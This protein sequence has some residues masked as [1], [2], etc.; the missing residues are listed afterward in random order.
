VN[1]MTMD[2]GRFAETKQMGD[3][4]IAAAQAAI[5][6]LRQLG[7]HA[8]L[9]ITPMLGVNDVAGET[10]TLAD[11]TA[12]TA[13]ARQNKDVALLA[14]WSIGRDNGSCS[15]QVSPLCSGVE[16]TEWQFARIFAAF[17]E[18]RPRK[19]IVFEGK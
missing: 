9:G 10:F 11:A 15:A 14:Y 16:Q 18:Q 4:A 17:V 8:R 2:Y 3:N 19:E 7:L 12:L 1:L 13:F 6:Q 5:E